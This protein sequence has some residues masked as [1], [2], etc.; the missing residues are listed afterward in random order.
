LEQ[1]HE[2]FENENVVSRRRVEGSFVRDE[3]ARRKLGFLAD[4]VIQIN[5]GFIG[6]PLSKAIYLLCSRSKINF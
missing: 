4:E 2:V 6:W 3:K 1:G 5:E